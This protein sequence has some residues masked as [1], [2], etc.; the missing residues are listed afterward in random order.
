M[1]IEPQ[2][3]HPGEET[4]ISRVVV[5]MFCAAVA[6]AFNALVA[7]A[8]PFM[9]VG[10]DE[11]VSFTD[12]KTIVSPPGKD[13][14]L[15]VDVANPLDPRI[16]ANLSLKNSVVGPPVNL[17]IDPTDSVAIVADSMNA[18][19][20]GDNWKQ[21]P[22]NKIYVIDLKAKPA[23]LISTIEGDRQPSGLSINAAGNLALVANRA[24]KSI[25]VLS[26]HGADVKLIGSV[27]MGDEVSAVVF[28]P[29]GKHALASKASANKVALLDV[30]GDK[31]TY[32]KHDLL[33]GLFPYNVVAA[34]NGS[35]A[36]TADNGNNGTSD[37]NVDTV[38][39][40]D[41]TEPVH[42]ID[43]IT[44]PDSPEGLAFSPKGNIAVAVEATG[45]NHPKTDFYYHSHG[46]VTVLKIDGKK[47][48][49]LND[50]EVG[51]LPEAVAFTPDGRYIYVGNYMDRDFS[52][53][54]VDGTNVT[55]TGK[56]FKVPGQPGSARMSPN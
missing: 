42:V 56:H 12:G 21:V 15:V 10:D 34:P 17:A 30:D 11:K 26:I 48:T 46:M 54:R 23:K 1:R 14:V 28:T 35:I 31:V 6:L 44:V 5:I 39:V 18:V 20:D 37:G 55:D 9:I 25:S 2:A 4:M 8:A 24:G 7:R 19:Q 36:L 50:I 22:D 13:S 16:V 51:A 27:D 41:L 49:R 43:H 38:S 29:D 40:I 3:E 53:L 47:V 52:I 32:N 33:T 45:S